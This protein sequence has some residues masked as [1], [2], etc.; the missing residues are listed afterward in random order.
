MIN[1]NKRKAKKLHEQALVL[2]NEG[3]TPEA[4]ALYEK[5]LELHEARSTTHYNLGLIYKYQGDWEKSLQH[6]MRAYE[7]DSDDEA[8]IWNM[9]IAATALERWDVARKAWKTYGINIEEGN[10]A[11]DLD[12]GITPVRL[13]TAGN[14]GEV[15]WAQRIDP[16]RTVIQNIPLPDSGFRYGDVVLND[17]APNGSR[18]Y[19]GHEYPVFDVLELLQVS[20]FSTFTLKLD[21]ADEEDLNVLLGVFDE[22]D[23]MMEDWTDSLRYLCQ[24]CSEGQVH[25]H[26]QIE[27]VDGWI[28]ERDVGV[29]ALNE[30]SIKELA[31]GWIGK[32]RKIVDI[33]E[34]LPARAAMN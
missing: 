4:I 32:G 16:A 22:A 31:D 8:V 13:V 9:G 18:V 6:N 14:G 25:E 3:N 11:P 26:E 7:L 17:G 2:E 10:D 21:V 5:A 19:G 15:V 29:A 30:A 28:S 23:I 20:K 24:E 12:F 1:F 27:E 33:V 34:S